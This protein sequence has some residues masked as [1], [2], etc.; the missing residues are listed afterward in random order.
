MRILDKLRLRFGSLFR[1]RRVEAQL[2]D[3]LHF[4]L[5]QLVNENISAG[6]SPDDARRSAL[7]SMGGITAIQEDCRDMRGTKWIDDFLRDVGYAWRSFNRNPAFFLSAILILAVGIGANSAVFTVVRAVVLNPLPFPNPHQLVILWKADQNDG[8][9]RSGIA[10]ADFLDLQQQVRSC[11]S[12]AAFTNTFFDVTGVNDPYRVVA[13]RVSSNFFSM[14]GL[15]PAAGRDFVSA[16]DLPTGPRVA[17]LSYSLWLRRFN[18]HPDVI[19]DNLTLNNERYTIIGVMPKFVPPE[20]VGASGGPDLWIPLRLA[21][22]RTERGSGYMRVVARLRTDKSLE[23]LRA[24]L[25]HLSRQFAKSQP[26]AYTRKFLAA[27]PLHE[28][29]V[30]R[31][32]QPLLV[33]WGAVVC[34]LLITCTNLA[35]M[36]LVRSTARIRELA[37]RASLGAS[38][39]RLVRQLLTENIALAL[40]GGSLGLALAWAAIRALP[41][42]GLRD[43][44][45]MDEVTIDGWVITFSLGLS[46]LTGVFFGTLPAWKISWLDPQ[47]SMQQGNRLMGDRR[48]NILR[49]LFVVVQVSLALILVTGAGLL[50]RS[51][52]ALQKTDLGFQPE[53]LLTFE[54]PLSGEKSKGERATRYYAEV[55]QRI[56]RLPQVQSVGGINYLPLRGNVF[57]WAFLIQ[58]RDTARGSSLPSAEYRVV[59]GD[60]FSALGIL[61]KAGRG[62]EERDNRAAPPVAV[63]NET[64]A[65]RYWP[66]EDPIGKQ[67]RLGGPLSIFPWM[68][69]IGVAGDVRYGDVEA[70]PE[71]T[72][73]QSL[74]QAGGGSLSIVVRANS[75]P[76]ALVSTIG[77]EVR[78]ID[79]DVPLLNIREFGYYVSESFAQRRLVLAV[80]SGFAGIALFLAAFGIYSVVSYSV[81][82]RTQ[83]I[84]LRVA[85]GARQG[86]ILKLILRQGMWAAIAG[87]AA[88]V[89]GTF[90]FAKAI[91]TLLYGVKPVDPLTIGLVCVLL[92][93]ITVL[94]SY[95]PAKRALQIDPVVAL[96]FD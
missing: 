66:G 40:C 41:N 6:M 34:V 53:H 79:R 47:R 54:L 38:H 71:P 36:L 19:G 23:N 27:V 60:L 59:S 48:G 49:G 39:W 43:L 4:H 74:S 17:I 51:F 12:I 83:E 75:A 69:V 42:I 70:A 64:M 2:E 25:E 95:L 68:T 50:I 52:V 46:A 15:R 9:Q 93:V 77:S 33:L 35:N 78:D 1:R 58:G 28:N 86:G 82:Q 45:R 32:R 61:M 76:T 8:A 62:F 30:G 87:I 22:E 94:A 85:L 37:V 72:I 13:A 5:D 67:F 14:L 84:G 63:I 21:Q 24:E 55:A 57:G 96:R 31:A 81:T 20:V 65:R 80:V 16:E 18:G 11:A 44:P 92:L 7:R 89:G 26:R 73:Y 91:T 90:A 3:E 88:G 10:P 56:S 29:V